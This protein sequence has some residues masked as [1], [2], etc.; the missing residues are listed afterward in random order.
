MGNEKRDKAS[1]IHSI[2]VGFA[3]V[4]FVYIL[5]YEQLF[6]HVMT[7][8]KPITLNELNIEIQKTE[9][10]LEGE[11]M[12]FWKSIKIEPEKWAEK[13]FGNE[14]GGFWVVAVYK[15]KVIWYN[16]IEDGFNLS[17]FEKVGEI[18]K[19]NCQDD[20]ISWAVTK[21]YNSAK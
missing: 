12:E 2:L 3:K 9:K 16:D 5:S 10:D 6:E 8:W 1:V 7:E 18:E 20:E 19:Y 11:I 14:G 17:E 13:E 15:N 4:C 21:L